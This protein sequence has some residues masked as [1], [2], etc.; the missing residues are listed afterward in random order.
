MLYWVLSPI[1]ELAALAVMANAPG[2]NRLWP[3]GP[4]DD[5]SIPLTAVV[6]RAS[7]AH[8]QCSFYNVPKLQENPAMR[9]PPKYIPTD[10][11]TQS[12][13]IDYINADGALTGA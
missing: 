11:S 3:R 2:P 13:H 6:R 8:P 12:G 9:D 4:G 1:R 7:T 10:F 5:V